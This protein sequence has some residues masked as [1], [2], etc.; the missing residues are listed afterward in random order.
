MKKQAQKQKKTSM[1]TK[2]VSIYD[3]TVEMGK[4]QKYI[5]VR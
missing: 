1:H 3:G 5:F 2:E 4:C